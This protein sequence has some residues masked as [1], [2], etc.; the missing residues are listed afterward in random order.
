MRL[1]RTLLLAALRTIHVRIR[2][3]VTLHGRYSI[4]YSGLSFFHA[5]TNF[6]QQPSSYRRRSIEMSLSI[7]T[8][9]LR[10]K[11]TP[12]SSA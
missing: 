11:I 10:L 1:S 3:V 4:L 12:R 8:R 5:R 9:Q 7:K 2:E 6:H